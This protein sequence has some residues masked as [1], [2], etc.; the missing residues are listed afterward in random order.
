MNTILAIL[1]TLKGLVEVTL[2]NITMRIN[3][4]ITLFGKSEHH[5]DTHYHNPIIVNV[6][7]PETAEKVAATIAETVARHQ[8]P[9]IEAPESQPL[10][11]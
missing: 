4:P 3:M 2:H 6:S 1:E 11:P 7:N 9:V 5:G 10:T 8:R